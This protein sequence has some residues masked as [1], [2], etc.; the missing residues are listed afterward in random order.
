[1][2]QCVW[3]EVEGNGK[4]SLQVVESNDW[5]DMAVLSATLQ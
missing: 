1:M 5:E 3:C 4:N 2:T